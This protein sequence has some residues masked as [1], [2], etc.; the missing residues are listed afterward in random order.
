MSPSASPISQESADDWRRAVRVAIR[1]AKEILIRD[2][3]TGVWI[4]RDLLV[5]KVHQEIPPELLARLSEKYAT[6]GGG[7]R[8]RPN[9]LPQ[10]QLV[11]SGARRLIQVVTDEWRQWKTLVAR[12]TGHEREV[13][14][15]R[16]PRLMR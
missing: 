7:G 10:E 5:V 1:L 2:C 13:M 16:K 11:W 15:L 4:K 8:S 6:C 3:Q 9:R 12:G 14:L